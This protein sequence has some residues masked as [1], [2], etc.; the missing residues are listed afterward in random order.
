MTAEREPDWLAV[1]FPRDTFACERCGR[2]I[3]A[4]ETAVLTP[5][6]VSHER[7]PTRWTPTVIDGGGQT[8]PRQ[9]PLL[10]P[11]TESL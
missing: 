6:A 9:L 1:I 7:C 10:A 8:S 5:D 11:V 4:G 2:A 3:P